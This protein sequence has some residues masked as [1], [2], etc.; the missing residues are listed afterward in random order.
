MRFRCHIM[1]CMQPNVPP[2]MCLQ[3]TGELQAH[4]VM[5]EGKFGGQMDFVNYEINLEEYFEQISSETF[6]KEEL[7]LTVSGAAIGEYSDVG[8]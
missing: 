5:K 2:F 8:M 7:H 1:T 3:C 6:T 4:H